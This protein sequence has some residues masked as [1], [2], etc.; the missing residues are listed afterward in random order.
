MIAPA[1]IFTSV[2]CVLTVCSLCV[3]CVF[4]VCALRA[5]L[6]LR[7][8]LVMGSPQ[9]QFFHMRLLYLLCPA[10]RVWSIIPVH[11][12]FFNAYKLV[13]QL[14]ALLFGLIPVLD[15]CI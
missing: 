11:F 5:L 4:T 10:F 8:V 13:G 12:P 15:Q 3:H 6:I 14:S 7:Q 1:P 2:N 9:I